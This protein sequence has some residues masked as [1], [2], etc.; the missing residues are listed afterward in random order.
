MITAI[1]VSL[2]VAA[3]ILSAAIALSRSQP[4]RLDYCDACGQAL[5]F[6]HGIVRNVRGSPR[7]FCL[8]C[9]RSQMGGAP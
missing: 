2:I 9:D 8:V 7:H 6:G 5:G 4:A 3:F 1:I